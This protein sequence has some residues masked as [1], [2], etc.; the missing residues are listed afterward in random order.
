[1]QAEGTGQGLG[2]L[3]RRRR[4]DEEARELRN[5]EWAEERREVKEDD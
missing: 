3:G 5:E 4:T 1:M 2:V